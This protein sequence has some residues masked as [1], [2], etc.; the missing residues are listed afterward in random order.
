MPRVWG[1]IHIIGAWGEDFRGPSFFA[2]TSFWWFQALFRLL[3]FFLAWLPASS[4]LASGRGRSSVGLTLTIGLGSFLAPFGPFSPFFPF[5][6]SSV[7][8]S[9]FPSLGISV[10]SPL[11][12][13]GRFSFPCVLGGGGFPFLLIST[14]HLARKLKKNL[15]R[16]RHHPGSGHEYRFPWSGVRAGRY[17]VHSGGWPTLLSATSGAPPCLGT[18]IPCSVSA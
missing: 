12:R 16:S 7:A 2:N 5:R 1:W 8:S 6:A 3:G 14:V 15:R 10:A 13:F 4:Y 17:P 18:I 9:P 11:R